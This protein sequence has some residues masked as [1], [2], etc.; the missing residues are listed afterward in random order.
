[1]IC[2]LHF[3]GVVY[4]IDRFVNIELSFH[5]KNKSHMNILYASH[6]TVSHFIL[7]IVLGIGN[8]IPNLQMEELGTIAYL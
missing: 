4:D 6:F 7:A 3:V 1:M 8:L 5:P 2:I